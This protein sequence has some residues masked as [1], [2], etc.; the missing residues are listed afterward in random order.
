MY[1]TEIYYVC[2]QLAEFPFFLLTPI[3]FITI[4]YWL[5]GLNP[6][7]YRFFIATLILI[8]NTQV[9]MGF[10]YTMSCCVSY[11]NSY[12]LNNKNL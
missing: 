11:Y 8:L 3:L 1:R 12:S 4:F 5:T 10:G 2:K 6:D 7:W 9:V